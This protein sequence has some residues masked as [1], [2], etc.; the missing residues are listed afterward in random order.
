[1][2]ILIAPNAFK[3]SL[4]ASAAAEAIRMGLMQ[5]GLPC[6]IECF[7]IGDGGDGT[8]SLIIK[9]LNGCIVETQASDPLGRKIKTSIGFIEG[10]KTAV[11]EMAD[12]SGLK[13]LQEQERDPLH[14]STFGTGEL[15][16]LAL[17]NGAGKIILGIG[18]SATVDGGCGVLMALGAR[19]LDRS[20]KELTGLPGNLFQLHSVDLSG[21][22]KRIWAT[23]LIVLCDVSNILLGEKGAAAVFGPQK[24]ASPGEVELLENGLRRLSEVCFLQTGKEMNGLRYGGAAGGT[25]AGLHVFLQAK[26]VHGIEYF[27]DIT[28]FDASLA[29]ADLL[30][31]G[32]GSID[33]QTLDGKGPF[34]VASR[35]KK[36]NIPVIGI[37]G[38]VP[39]DL[40]AELD[41]YFDSLIAIGH[42]PEDINSAVLH[43]AENLRHTGR[44]IGKLMVIGLLS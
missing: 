5:S 26:L 29:K 20:K 19:F 30:V 32:E 13:L 40:N 23:E 39:S 15:I 22:D 24:G 37:A 43:T 2:H 27:L 7:P 31:T 28:G 6:S 17:E 10:G 35:A 14:A 41:H 3:N 34:G 4:S 36:K 21:I 11:I 1:M 9:N 38:K 25:A 33:R 18:G 8:A 12:I 42:Q 16:R 44:Q